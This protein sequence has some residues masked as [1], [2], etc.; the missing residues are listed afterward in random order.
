MST[1]PII[2][3]RQVTKTYGQGA[4][5]V[6]VLHGIDLTVRPQE[7]VAIMGQ[8]GSGKSTLMNII[9]TLDRMTS[10]QYLFQDTPIQNFNSSQLAQLRCRQIG[11]VFQ[12]FN[13]LPRLTVAKNIARP[14]MY[15]Q[16]P[17]DIRRQRI[18]DVLAAVGLSHKRDV[19]PSQLS[20]GQQQRVALARALVMQPALILADEPTGAL[21]STTATQVMEELQRINQDTGTTIILITHDDKV[22]T[23]ASRVIHISDGKVVS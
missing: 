2:C 11:F 8:S 22:A 9:G 3:L 1:S 21:D 16:V 6:E 18:K 5:A 4:N 7:F 14:L 15:A 12:S 23:Y 10:G 17:P 20:G 19:L 13:L